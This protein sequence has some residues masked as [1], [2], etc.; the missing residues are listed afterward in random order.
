MLVGVMHG[1]GNALN[2][3]GRPPRRQG[4]APDQPGQILAFDAIH[5]EERLTLDLT[6]FV[7]GDDV[8]VPEARRGLGFPTEA[9]DGLLA[10]QRPQQ[11][12]L[13]GDDPVEADLPSPVNDPHPAVSD[14]LEQFVIAEIT[15]PSLTEGQ[16]RIGE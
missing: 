8:G 6:D 11:Q 7:D 3:T 1:L 13:H 16:K 12:H 9:L 10:R 4:T 15:Q 14:L 5:R 2:V